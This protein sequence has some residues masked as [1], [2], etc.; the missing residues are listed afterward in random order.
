MRETA[1]V[2]AQP[3]NLSTRIGRCCKSHTIST[4]EVGFTLRRKNRGLLVVE[5]ASLAAKYSTKEKAAQSSGE[6]GRAITTGVTFRERRDSITDSWPCQDAGFCGKEKRP[7]W[8]GWANFQ[9]LLLIHRR[10]LL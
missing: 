6:L 5:Q 7:N 9:G 2:C 3:A 10:S 4:E 1:R 8:S